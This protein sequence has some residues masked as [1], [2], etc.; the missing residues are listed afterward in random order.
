MNKIPSL[1]SLAA[2]AALSF[3]GFAPS[4]TDELVLT[5]GRRIEWS[6]L[7]DNGETYE[8]TASDGSRSTV[9]K[10]AV[11]EFV[12]VAP[13]TPLTGA[14]FK[15]EGVERKLTTVNMFKGLDLKK[16][17]FNALWSE[18]QGEVSATARPPNAGYLEFQYSPPEEYD[19]LLSA[20]MT[21]GP[22]SVNLALVGGGRP[23]MVSFNVSGKTVMHV[24]D[25]NDWKRSTVT[26]PGD[27][28]SPKKKVELSVMVRKD[29]FLIRA[30]DRDHLSWRGDW[31][32]VSACL[33]NGPRSQDVI[34]LGMY[35]AS[36]KI[37][38]AVVTGPKADIPG[39]KDE[40]VPDKFK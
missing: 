34:S 5:D 28:F 21:E 7:K 16:A 4:S 27:V 1:L 13:I 38:R 18:G 23:F 37:S 3:A 36:M 19:L 33:K 39:Q 6:S 15:V 14:T 31:K 12:K 32:R 29:G 22:G 40:H 17:S 20:E 30:D 10:D 35:D 9:K 11:R 2:L 8:V 26:A 24:V 25:G